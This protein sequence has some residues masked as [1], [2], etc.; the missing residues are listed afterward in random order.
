MRRPLAN[1]LSL[2]RPLMCWTGVCHA[3]AQRNG[4]A[5]S[6]PADEGGRVGLVSAD[7]MADSIWP[8]RSF[9][10]AEL[11]RDIKPARA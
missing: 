9:S 1:Q 3:D 4:S 7:G 2:A 5:A 11:G 8:I 10:P 6:E